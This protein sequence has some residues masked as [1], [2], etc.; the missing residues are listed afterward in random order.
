MANDYS[1]EK[2]K[3]QKNCNSTTGSASANKAGPPHNLCDENAGW[4]PSKNPE[5]GMAG[6]ST[7]NIGSE[8]LKFGSK[9]AASVTELKDTM[10]GK[11]DQIEEML[12]K[13]DIWAQDTKERD[14]ASEDDADLE[15]SGR[16]PDEPPSKMS[17]L[18]SSGEVAKK[19]YDL[20]I[21][22]C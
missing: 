7:G 8:F 13:P 12:T 10:A 1:A 4:C 22:I 20:Q 15:I 16:T 17:K 3:N 5:E 9:L 11:F 6:K 19:Q 21:V 2:S 18:S 14:D